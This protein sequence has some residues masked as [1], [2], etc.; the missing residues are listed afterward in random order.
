MTQSLQHE[1][2]S[3][4]DMIRQTD[5]FGNE[6]WSARD[7][8]QLMGYS[9][10][11]NFES[12]L[13][14]AM[15][16]ARN[17][18]QTVENLFLRSQEKTSGRPRTDYRLARYAAYLVAMNGDPNMPEVASAQS[19]FAIQ[20][21]VAETQV[22][23]QPQLSDD[24][25]M[26]RA[27]QISHRRVQELQA[28]VE[29]TAPKAEAYDSFMDADGT[30]SVGTVAKMLGLS[31]NKL[32]QELRNHRVLISKGAMRNTPYQQYMHH[33]G[34]KAHTFNRSDG[35]ES[36]SYTTRVQSSGVDFI[37]RKLRI[38]KKVAA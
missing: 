16:T 13:N 14:R 34:V 37:R 19:Y 6:F 38:E 28:K 8:S 3:P 27:L 23:Q 32:F 30:Y 36:T 5:D 29:E 4:F 11:E 15:A 10:W 31:Q 22:L 35:S 20:T 12:P 17:E 7:L 24:E 1:S 18:G 25:I 2:R 21:R 26:H 33:F 9:R